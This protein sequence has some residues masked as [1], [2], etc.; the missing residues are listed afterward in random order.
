MRVIAILAVAGLAVSSGTVNAAE[1]QTTDSTTNTFQS[2]PTGPPCATSAA[3]AAAVSPAPNTG[4]AASAQAAAGDGMSAS[5]N[6][7]ATAL[8]GASLVSRLV[9]SGG[10]SVGD[11][12]TVCAFIATA[13]A[14]SVSG[15]ANASGAIGGLAPETLPATVT[16]IRP[17]LNAS[18][19]FLPSQQLAVTEDSATSAVSCQREFTM[20]IGESL[21]LD[22]GGKA[23]ASIT[24]VGQAGAAAADV[25]T[26]TIGPCTGGGDVCASQVP[27]PFGAPAASPG[28]LG[29]IAGLL[30]L[31]GGRGL[32][33]RFRA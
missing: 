10:D 29:L 8:G 20:R 32:R 11:P 19:A 24:G 18:V 2:P 6:Q 7:T 30:A 15:D 12:V 28:V 13:I 23:V 22:I 14:L 16:L 3:A 9:P 27:P 25:I 31:L 26:V 17:G 1:F 21:A 4:L 33:R 5:C